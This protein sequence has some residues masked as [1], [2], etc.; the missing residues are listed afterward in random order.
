[1]EKK[2]GLFFQCFHIR[3]KTVMYRKYLW[4]LKG[5]VRSVNYSTINCLYKNY[6][7]N[8]SK[9]SGAS[10]GYCSELVPYT[11]KGN[12]KKFFVGGV[13]FTVCYEWQVCL[14]CFASQFPES[15]NFI[16]PSMDRCVRLI[17]CGVRCSFHWYQIICD[18]LIT[19]YPI[20]LGIANRN[21]FWRFFMV[22]YVYCIS[23]FT[24]VAMPFTVCY[25]IKKI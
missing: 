19:F 1:M 13:E 7:I 20:F 14:I 6:E 25:F 23:I 12:P 5:N 24:D 16:F 15:N 9:S 11:I 2:S 3:A 10:C 17:L 4:L 22:L 21:Q 8:L 18:F